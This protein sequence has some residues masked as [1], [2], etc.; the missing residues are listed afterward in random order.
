M[1]WRGILCLQEKNKNPGSVVANDD[2]TLL[3][4]GRAAPRA[5]RWSREGVLSAASAFSEEV[6]DSPVIL[7]GRDRLDVRGRP[8]ALVVRCRSEAVR[9]G[10]PLQV[11]EMQLAERRKTDGGCPAACLAREQVERETSATAQCELLAAIEA[12]C[13]NYL[14]HVRVPEQASSIGSGRRLFA[15]RPGIS[16]LTP[17]GPSGRS[18]PGRRP[19]R[20]GPP[21]NR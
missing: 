14:P 19:N 18:M 20:A 12:L 7:L 5:S 13:S 4:P 21:S 10:Q 8:H 1:G 17:A 16:L 15:R 6:L 9:T 3:N 2:F 11:P